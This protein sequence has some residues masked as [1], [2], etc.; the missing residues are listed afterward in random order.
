MTEWLLFRRKVWLVWLPTAGAVAALAFALFLGLR[1]RAWN[2]G[3]EANLVSI[4][5]KLRAYS[6]DRETLP[7]LSFFP[8]DVFTDPDSLYTV[9]APYGLRAEECVCPAIKR[10]LGDLGITYVWNVRL[11]G[12]AWEDLGSAAWLLVEINALSRNAPRPHGGHYHIL[13]ADGRVER[14]PYPPP[15][16]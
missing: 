9:L 6:L 1:H 12:R 15:G 7:A 14:S 13:Y 8:D 16:L 4:Y 11:N 10:H 2:R 5:E 3:C